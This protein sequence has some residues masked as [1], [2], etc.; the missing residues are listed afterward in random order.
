LP[1]EPFQLIIGPWQP[2]HIVAG[3]QSPPKAAKD[4]VDVIGD[5][6][7]FGIVGVTGGQRNQVIIHGLSDAGATFGWI[8]LW[9]E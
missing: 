5:P 6:L 7:V 9:V 3:E 1:H 2:W 4:L 8:A